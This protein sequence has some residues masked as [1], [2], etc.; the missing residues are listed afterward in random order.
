VREGPTYIAQRTIQ[1]SQKDQH[2]IHA[3]QK[4]ILFI[5]S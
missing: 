3:V 2:A 4:K 1:S 5:V